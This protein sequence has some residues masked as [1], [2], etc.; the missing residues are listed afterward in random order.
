M[1][2]EG[3]IYFDQQTW[4]MVKIILAVIIGTLLAIVYSMRLLVLMERRVARMEMHIEKIA[5]KIVHEEYRIEKQLGK[6][7]K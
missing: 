7:K 6:K 1:V 2:V 5:A 3:S 4:L